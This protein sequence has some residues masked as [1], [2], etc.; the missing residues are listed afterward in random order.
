MVRRALDPASLWLIPARRG[1]FVS[2]FEARKR[3]ADYVFSNP[4]NKKGGK[5]HEE[6][7][8]VLSF[9]ARDVCTPELCFR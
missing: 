5:V 4:P 9:D 7:I 6:V 1:F 8:C 3:E 2:A